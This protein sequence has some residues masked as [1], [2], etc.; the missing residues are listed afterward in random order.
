MPRL[1]GVRNR[2]HQPFWDSI[3]RTTG[4]PTPVL[5]ASKTLFTNTVGQFPITNM[6]AAGQLPSDQTY[7]VLSM[8]AWL[9]FKGTNA[10]KNYEQTVSQLYLS[11][12]M[13]DAQPQ[14]QAPV[15]YFPTGGGLY[16]Q[17]NA[18]STAVLN[19]GFP[20]ANAIVKFA[21]PIILPVRQHFS[22]EATWWKV[23]S[24]DALSTLNSGA[25]DDQK[26]IL[27]MIDG[28]LTRDVG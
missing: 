3:I 2:I 14:F 15:W 12:N 13:G 7:V 5:E 28:L 22:V 18:G 1:H 9:Y 26:S 23:G 16:G 6:K 17:D 27:I 25:T 10:V 8:R 4:D 19:N 11:L 21:R 24:T 20:S